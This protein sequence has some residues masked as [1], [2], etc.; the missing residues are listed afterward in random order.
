NNFSYTASTNW[1]MLDNLSSSQF[2]VVMFLDDAPQTAAQRTGF[3][4]YL[5]NG[6]AW[7][8][9]HVTAFNTDPSTW[10]WYYNQLLGTGAFVSNTWGPTVANLKVENQH[11]ATRRLGSTFTSAVSEWYSWTND[12]RQNPN[13]EILASVDPSSFPLG[14]DPNQSWFSGYFPILWTNKNYKMLYAN[15]GHNWMNYSTNT[16]LSTTFGSPAEDAFVIDGL[17]WLGGGA[18]SN[19][20]TNPIPPANWYTIV[21]SANGKCVDAQGAGTTNGTVI[22]QFTCNGTTAQGFRFAQTSGPYLQIDNRNNPNLG[23]DVTGVSTADNAPIHL[24]TYGGGLNQQW[25]AVPEGNGTYHIVSRN[26]AG[27]E[28]LTVPNSSTADGVQ[29]T[30]T[31]CTGSASQSFRL[32]Q[33]P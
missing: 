28:C 15:F 10:D 6:G 17:L 19:A 11:A 18:P 14:T 32:N 25:Q 13:I 8:G 21:N 16:P 26:G 23:L 29:L 33:Q 24:W 9:F 5:Q 20:P 22:Q 4:H 3:Q 2:Q 7:F 12:L 27:T 30:Q 31:A 1:D